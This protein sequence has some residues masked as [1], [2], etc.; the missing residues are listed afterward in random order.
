MIATH[1]ATRKAILFRDMYIDILHA[2]YQSE[3][4]GV[5]AGGF[6]GCVEANTEDTNPPRGD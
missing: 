3:Q 4:E 6:H 1:A 2:L 5:I